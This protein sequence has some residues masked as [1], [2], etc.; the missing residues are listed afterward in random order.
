MIALPH[1][2]TRK[3]I[4]IVGNIGSGKSTLTRLHARAIP[5]S[6]AVPE[7]FADNPFL[8]P[9]VKT[10]RRW[11]FTNAVRY[12]YDYARV[13]AERTAGHPY[14]HCFIDAGGA[15]NREVYGRYLE[16]EKIM[17]REESAFYWTL[18]DLIQT[19][20]EYPEPDAFIFVRCKPEQCFARMT[21][22]GWKYQTQNIRLRYLV[23]LERYFLNFRDR[24]KAGRVPLLELDSG[25]LDFT[26]RA[27]RARAVALVRAFLE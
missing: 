7:E 5:D 9:F 6:V 2:K 10:P 19:A 16:R 26:T 17:T 12:Y 23:T 1:S 22:R 24:L 13:Y 27:G 11:A 4:C 20:F 14:A 8:A 3:N 15:T 18:C 21:R 25:E